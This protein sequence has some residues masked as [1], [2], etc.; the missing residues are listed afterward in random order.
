[1]LMSSPFTGFA[2]AQGKQQGEPAPIPTQIST[3]KKVFIANAGGDDPGVLEPLFSGGPDRAYNQFHA[4]MKSAAHY[5]LVGS[6]A[7]ADLLFEVRFTV[8]PDKRPSGI[9][10]TNGTGDAND[11]VFR[12]EVRD[13][14][15]NA[16]LWAYNEHMEWAILQGNRNKNFDQ[17]LARLVADVAG[18]A[19]RAAAAT[20]QVKPKL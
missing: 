15:M 6:P 9:W 17:A 12:L 16:L 7:E 10:G 5:E 20:A 14:K 19:T 8:I 18:L 3:A 11:A 13:P 1:M 4:A 2:V